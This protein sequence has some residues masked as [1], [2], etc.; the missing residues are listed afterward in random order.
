MSEPPS[1]QALENT[2]FDVSQDGHHELLRCKNCSGYA[3][4]CEPALSYGESA[5][6]LNCSNKRNLQTNKKCLAWYIC[7]GCEC[8]VDSRQH[9]IHFNG[10]RH[11]RKAGKTPQI[12]H[13][14]KEDSFKISDL[15]DK[16]HQRTKARKI[17]H[18]PV[19]YPLPE[20]HLG[21]E[22]K[23]K[24]SEFVEYDAMNDVDDDVSSVTH[25]VT[26][27]TLPPVPQQE[28]LTV[29]QAFK[30][31]KKASVVPL[32]ASF[33]GEE[34]MSLYFSAERSKPRGGVLYL[35][36]RAFKKTKYIVTTGTDP[37]S[38]TMPT[39][40]ES[41]WHFSVF[42]QYILMNDAL[43]R[44]E[45]FI[46]YMLSLYGGVDISLF[47]ATRI[48]NY[49][50]LNRY[51]GRSNQHTLWNALPI[52]TVKNVSGI[53]YISL[54]DIIRYWFAFS[55][56][57]DSTFLKVPLNEFESWSPPVH[58]KVFHVNQCLAFTKW[59]QELFN[60]LK[61]FPQK[62]KQ[63]HEYV[64]M[65]WA[66]DW[67][68]GFGANRTKQN[69]KSTNAWTFSLA[70]PQERINS[71]S[72]TLPMALG[73]KK[74]DNWPQ[75]EHMFRGD[76]EE[77]LNGLRPLMVYHGGEKKL[78]P[79]FVRRLCCLTDKVERGDYTST[80]S[81]TS[82]YHRYFGY[83]IHFEPPI[84]LVEEIQGFLGDQK[85]GAQDDKLRQYGWSCGM[86][87][88]NKN[89]GRFPACLNCR[90]A[91]VEWLRN[92]N[93]QS[94]PAQSCQVCS[95]WSLNST[96]KT[97]LGFAAPKDYPALDRCRPNC[98][99]PVPAGREPGSKTLHYVQ[100]SFDF[101]KQAVRFAYFHSKSRRGGWTKANC[102]AYLRTCGIN[103]RQQELLYSA[104]VAAHDD[105]EEVDYND[106]FGVGSY[107]FPAAWVG[108]MPLE[109]FI[110]MLM[111]LLFLGMA[112]S[113]FKLCNLFMKRFGRPIETFKKKIQLLLKDLTVFKLSWLLA[114]PFSGSTK[115][116]L[117][118]G[119][120]VSENW[121]AFQRLSKIVYAY[122]LKRGLQDE[123]LGSNEVTRLVCAYVA[124]LA[125]V[126]SHSGTTKERIMEV[127]VYLKE[128]L[129]CVSEL[130]TRTRFEAMNALATSTS[131]PPQA[132]QAGRGEEKNKEQWWLKSNYVSALNLIRGMEQLGPLINFWDGGGKGERY[133]QEI[134]PHIPRGVRDGGNFFVRL[135]QRVLKQDCIGRIEQGRT[136]GLDH[137]RAN[138]DHD[139]NDDDSSHHS[140][141]HSADV[142]VGEEDANNSLPVVRGV[143]I[144][145]VTVD[146][147]L[148]T[149]E[150]DGVEDDL[151]DDGEGDDFDDEEE[152]WSTPMEAKQMDKARTYY[153]YKQQSS[154][155]DALARGEPVSGI[156]VKGRER[157]NNSAEMYLVYKIPGKKFGWF[158]VSFDDSNGALVCG[159][160]YA[161]IQV[162]EAQYPPSNT[163]EITKLARS[164]TI[165]IPLRYAWGDDQPHSLKYCVL[166][167]WWRERNQK[168]QYLLP[169][170][171]SELYEEPSESAEA[172]S[173]E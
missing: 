135:L 125:R 83:I 124:L 15:D 80:L 77:L 103:T 33:R 106:P 54:G 72:N 111:H 49:R 136:L 37:E 155:E 61:D 63:E 154:V 48:L 116:K 31:L 68:D 105:N 88:P 27:P 152:Q 91:N 5:F 50:E 146:D 113:N 62:F 140:S 43:R 160:W 1:F 22:L 100:L 26:A 32:N 19:E 102:Q 166:T 132:S 71:L 92:P 9:E 101:M 150:R 149:H 172:P 157:N 82:N 118:T 147:D 75:V 67:R 58:S 123:R 109:K 85:S 130:D 6:I 107:K 168:G 25:A 76:S 164:S 17:T 34:N 169:T 2:N 53:A 56:E 134:K 96:T 95:N 129:S 70:T 36:A 79:V 69:R 47:Q 117:T 66:V 141:D 90:R 38:Q 144:A 159:L 86:I 126:L 29:E 14:G 142:L 139:N 35:V 11:H 128:F 46:L 24:L 39:I 45:A 30:N 156:L 84:L 137:L 44:R 119:T 23:Q 131:W 98:P 65:C 97:Q 55:A 145:E 148:S 41:E 8:R 170:I 78:I 99:V 57:V 112:E 93:Y 12:D 127:Q 122:T 162:E 153:I 143:P 115:S 21:L 158:K 121:Y 7:L 138:H 114:Y 13:P 94:L 16:L 165:A 51:Y 110:E 173:N 104:A 59:K 81:C 171:P 151:S 64:L 87:T 161:P 4:I 108:D 40:F 74:N 163:E 89:G 18:N 42:V 167:N 60:T 28:P 133:I 10:T 52:P 3:A 20:A 73:L 120:W